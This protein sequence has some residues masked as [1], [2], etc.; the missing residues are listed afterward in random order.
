[1]EIK[2]AYENLAE[3]KDNPRT[4]FLAIELERLQGRL[5]ETTSLA[6]SDPEMAELA[7]EDIAAIERQQA[8]VV[9]EITEILKVEEEE[10]KFPNKLILE[11]RAGAGGDEASLFAYELGE[12]YTNY[13]ANQGWTY[14]TLNVSDNSSGGYKEVVYE[15]SGLDCY[16]KL[17]FETGVHRVQR[18]PVT[19]SKGRVHTSTVSVAILPVRKKINFELKDEDLEIEFTRAGGKGGQNVN[20]VETAV[21]LTHIPTGTTV[22]V[23]AE[24]SQSKN[25]EKAMSMLATRIEEEMKEQA[26]RERSDFRA[27]QIGSGDR[28]EKIRTYNFPQNRITDHRIKESWHKI[29][30]ALAGEIDDILTDLAEAQS[31]LENSE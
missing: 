27:K 20:K 24:R 30:A 4:Q 25:R 2:E 21:R 6:D 16:R 31:K 22:R 23:A 13:A 5:A 15:V 3:L 9:A 12:M 19:E 18:I 28:S 1:M 14:R 8:G 7:A 10:E 11:I 29:E 17:R 26:A